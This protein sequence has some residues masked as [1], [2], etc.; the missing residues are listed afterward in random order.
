MNKYTYKPVTFFALTLAL[1]WAAWFSA[2]YFSY[3]P[4]GQSVEFLL[5]VLGSN[6]PLVIGLFMVFGS[7]NR[8][9]RRDF[10]SRLF[11]IKRIDLRYTP[12][13]FLLMPASM[14][15]ATAVSLLFG[16]SPA[17]FRLSDLFDIMGGQASLGLLISILAPTILAG[18][19]LA[20]L[21]LHSTE[22]GFRDLLR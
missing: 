11:G 1:T 12:V 18:G 21:N 2:A 7:G 8:D 15:L 22:E 17:Q 3:Q 10:T 19:K 5:I 16:M 9:L 6:V 13:I 14:L 20:A 4:E